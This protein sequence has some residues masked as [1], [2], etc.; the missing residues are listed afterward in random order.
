MMREIAR[1]LL[2]DSPT[3]AAGYAFGLR[4]TKSMLV[5]AS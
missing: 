5:M 2:Q 1:E 4:A 3:S